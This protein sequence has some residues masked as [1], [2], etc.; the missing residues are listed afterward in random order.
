[1]RAVNPSPR[2]ATPRC[3]RCESSSTPIAAPRSGAACPERSSARSLPRPTRRNSRGSKRLRPQL[4]ARDDAGWFAIRGGGAI[5]LRFG[6]RVRPTVEPPAGNRRTVWAFSPAKLHPVKQ[7]PCPKRLRCREFAQGVGRLDS[8]ATQHSGRT[9]PFAQHWGGYPTPSD[10]VPVRDNLPA[11]HSFRATLV[12]ARGWHLCRLGQ[13]NHMIRPRQAPTN[14]ATG[15]EASRTAGLWRMCSGLH[16]GRSM[17]P[18]VL[19]HRRQTAMACT[20]AARDELSTDGARRLPV[21]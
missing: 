14:S 7:T 1:M 5:G 21:R 3:P 13:R 20:S 17:A 16:K 8:L 10:R 18:P 4:I 6:P 19:Q 12:S 11:V 2:T 9:E 15:H